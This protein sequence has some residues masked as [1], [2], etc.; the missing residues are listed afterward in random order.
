MAPGQ[1][2]SLVPPLSSLRSF[3][4]KST[5]LKQVLVTLLG[6]LE[7]LAVIQ[8]PH[9]APG[10]LCLPCRPRF[11]PAV[12]FNIGVRAGKFL[13]VRRIF[14]WIPP[15]L[16]EKTPEKRDLRKK[17][18]PCYLGA[19]FLKSKHVGRHFLLIFSGS[20]LRFSGIL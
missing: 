9:S 16:P 1:E 12:V 3:G 19:I 11:T 8:R 5:V 17:A 10:E 6:L 7:P 18:H 20:L 15:K 4:N 13:E 2:A 14:A